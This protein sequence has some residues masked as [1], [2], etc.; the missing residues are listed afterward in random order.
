MKT[1]SQ[2]TCLCPKLNQNP[3]IRSF[4]YNHK[5]LL[6][7]KRSFQCPS[8]FMRHFS[9]SRANK[10]RKEDKPCIW[11]TLFGDMDSYGHIYLNT[12][13]VHDV[14]LRCYSRKSTKYCYTKLLHVKYV[15]MSREVLQCLN[16]CSPQFFFSFVFI[17]KIISM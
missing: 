1:I 6:E 16:L 13:K 9:A 7:T 10:K 8:S 17:C 4:R 15:N 3:L 2:L 12:S 5:I 11:I 14:Y